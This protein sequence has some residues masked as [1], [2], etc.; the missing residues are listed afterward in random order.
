V[1][2]PITEE[3]FPRRGHKGAPTLTI[4]ALADQFF[5]ADDY[6]PADHERDAALSMI[7]ALLEDGFTREQVAH[8]IAWYTTHHAHER[9]LGRLPYLITQALSE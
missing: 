9:D 2:S 7:T 8:A 4:G 6:A 3:T 1:E 5:A